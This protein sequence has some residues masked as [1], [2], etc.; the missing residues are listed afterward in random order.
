[1]LK[2]IKHKNTARTHKS[3]ALLYDNFYYIAVPS[4][5]RFKWQALADLLWNK[6]SRLTRKQDGK[7]TLIDTCNEH[8][9]LVFR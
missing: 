6:N 8:I 3:K 4:H 7:Q 9:G 2:V 1:M 5:G